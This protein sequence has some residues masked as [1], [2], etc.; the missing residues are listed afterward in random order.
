MLSILHSLTVAHRRFLMTIQIAGAASYFPDSDVELKQL[1]DMKLLEVFHS[2]G[3]A[4]VRLTRHG[5]HIA[6]HL[7]RTELP[8]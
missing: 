6:L 8:H 4:R 3:A 2:R 5:E 7:L 1:V